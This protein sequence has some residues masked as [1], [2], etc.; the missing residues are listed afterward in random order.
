M[1][2]MYIN[3][4]EI[5]QMRFGHK[6]AKAWIEDVNGVDEILSFCTVEHVE[7]LIVRCP[8]SRLDVV[9][10]LE[11]EGF[12]LMDTQCYYTCD[13]NGVD[14][15][16]SSSP[17]TI[18][19]YMTGDEEDIRRLAR[20]A[21]QGY[22]GHYHN[23]ER[24]DRNRCDEVYEDW[25]YRSCIDK[26]VADDVIIVEKDEKIVG[27]GTLREES[28][29]LGRCVLVGVSKTCQGKGIYRKIIEK[30]MLWCLERGITTLEVSTQ[31]VNIAVQKVWVRL[32]FEPARSEYVFHKWF[33]DDAG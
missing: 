5:D 32:G 6:T 20:E 33:L 19:Y 3:L 28:R 31:I 8:S 1:Q 11:R 30:A 12:R 7:F 16:I 18:R 4:S 17:F 23:D 14:L 21:F 26:K 22:F 24:L 10:F 15:K 13:V 25:A 27:F 9:H 29:S 2:S